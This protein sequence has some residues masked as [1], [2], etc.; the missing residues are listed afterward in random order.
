MLVLWGISLAFML[1]AGNKGWWTLSV[2]TSMGRS[3]VSRPAQCL[4]GLPPYS[5]SQG[6]SMSLELTD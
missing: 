5:L 3:Q 4:T 6:L 2:P 1:R